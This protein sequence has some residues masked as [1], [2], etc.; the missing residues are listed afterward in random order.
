MALIFA[1]I[2]SA[3]ISL[4]YST[5]TGSTSFFIWSRPAKGTRFNLPDYS[6]ATSF[7]SSSLDSIWRP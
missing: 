4:A 1:R 3:P 2:W 7:C 5:I 6:I